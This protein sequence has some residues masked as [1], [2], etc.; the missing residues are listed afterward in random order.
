MLFSIIVSSSQCTA[1]KHFVFLKISL[2]IFL[3]STSISPVDD[4]INI[5]IAPTFF[6][7]VFKTSSRLLLETPI[8]NV[9]LAKDFSSPIL[10]FS[11]NNF[12]VK[13][14]G[15]VLGISINDVTPPLI[16]ALLSDEISAL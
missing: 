7:S 1:I 16:A 12:C 2:R 6:V 3:S 14:C 11:S 4:P 9:K 10:N 5:L 13:V 8:K 15:L